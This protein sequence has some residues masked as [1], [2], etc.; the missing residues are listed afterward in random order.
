LSQRPRRILYL[1]PVGERG[2]AEVVLL[3]ILR[4]ID[5]SRFEPHVVLLADGPLRQELVGLA[6]SIHVIREHRVRHIWST[7]AAIVQLAN[8]ARRL[9]IDLIHTQG[10]KTHLYGGALRKLTGRRELWHIYDPPP[11]APSWVDRV[12]TRVATDQ[13]VFISGGPRD[14]FAPLMDVAE[15]VVIHPGIGTRARPTPEEGSRVLTRLGIAARARVILQVSRL[16]AFKG[17]EYLLR[18]TA[19]LVKV[20][21]DV[22]VVMV[23]DTLFG[24]EPEY[25]SHLKRLTREL[26]LES[27]VHLAGWLPDGELAALYHHAAC[28]CY[29]EVASPYSLVILEAMAAGRPVVATRTDGSQILV[30][31]GETGLLVPPREPEALAAALGRLLSDGA[32]AARLGAQGQKRQG[33]KFTAAGMTASIQAVYERMLS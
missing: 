6:E 15:A 19:Q 33:E 17:H 23:G 26:G 22:R 1:E 32:L 20:H 16:Q 30:E 10:T 9:E 29:A 14:A 8:L 7:L 25:R 5:R 2:G 18:A 13:A 27:V 12:T 11:A 3:D 21:P 24:L 31:E 28:L 4:H